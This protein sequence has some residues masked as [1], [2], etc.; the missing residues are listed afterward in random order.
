V[1]QKGD[2]FGDAQQ[3]ERRKKGE[4]KEIGSLTEQVKRE[5]TRK[6]IAEQVK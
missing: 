5:G 2:Q 6:P 3:R 1:H 4:E